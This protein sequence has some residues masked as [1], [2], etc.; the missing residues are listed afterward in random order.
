MSPL[1]DLIARQIRHAGPMSLGEYMAICL[2]HPEFGYYAR[3]APIGVAGAFTT[4]P[5]VSQMFGEL[6][7]LWLAKCWID[8]GSPKSFTL[9]E[10]GPGYGTLMA[11]I[12]RAT[13]NVGGF[14]NAAHTFLIE[15]SEPLKNRQ[16]ETLANHDVGWGQS[17][18]EIPDRPLFLVANEFFDAL[19]IRQF[20][21]CAGHWKEIQV[22]VSNGRLALGHSAALP[23]RPDLVNF[24]SSAVGDIVE[25]R[26]SATP[27]IQEV[28]RRIKGHGGVALIIDYGA[29]TLSGNTFQAVRSHR[30]VDPLDDPG[31]ADLT[32][33]VDFGA[34][35][36]ASAV[37]VTK[38]TAQGA[39]L[40][41][42]GI[43]ARAK[44]LAHNMIMQDLNSH[45]AGLRRLIHPDEMGDLFKVLALYPESASLPPGFSA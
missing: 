16:R 18:D 12:L 28:S 13:R 35:A 14:A 11:D 34:L 36:S 37:P 32:A 5:E 19:P 42:I 4:A 31:K 30:Q 3:E 1:G 44:R 29:E 27:V 25:I 8:Q 41:N 20:A 40:K 21:R 33:H 17:V 7:G 22:G 43:E 10:L 45:I 39:F 23:V 15:Q 6:V 26:T 9:C 38:L 2:M 24:Q